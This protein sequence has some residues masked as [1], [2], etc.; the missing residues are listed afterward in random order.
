MAVERWVATTPL[1]RRVRLS[2]AAWTLKILDRHPEFGT[3]PGYEQELRL[4]LEK[5]GAA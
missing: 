4:A 2:E 5:P 3:A 1:G